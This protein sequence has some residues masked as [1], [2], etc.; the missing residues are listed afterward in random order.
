MKHKDVE[1]VPRDR[2]KYNEMNLVINELLHEIGKKP[3]LKE[4]YEKGNKNLIEL[5]RIFQ[6][7]KH[8]YQNT[9]SHMVSFSQLS[10]DTC[11]R[12]ARGLKH[13]CDR[14][15]S[16]KKYSTTHVPEEPKKKRG[17]GRPRKDGS[18]AIKTKKSKSQT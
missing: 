15:A 2:T 11:V 7:V 6:E 10:W 18:T 3:Q 9:N 5:D 16:P 13:D 8:I 17:R 14:P 4:D 1:H 12:T